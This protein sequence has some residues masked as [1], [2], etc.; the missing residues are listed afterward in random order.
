MT[1]CPASS[2]GCSRRLP[3][4]PRPR[5]SARQRALRETARCLTRA[6]L[7]PPAGSPPHPSP[8]TWARAL[9]ALLTDPGRL[10]RHPDPQPPRRRTG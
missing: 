9:E 4:R 8:L 7:T 10:T 1:G 2:R 5:A 6:G 3:R